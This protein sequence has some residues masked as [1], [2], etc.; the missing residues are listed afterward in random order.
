MERV[1]RIPTAYNL[2]IKKELAAVG[3]WGCELT[4]AATSSDG[5]LCLVDQR[6]GTEYYSQGSISNR[7]QA[8]RACCGD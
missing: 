1:P 7:E 5:N 8:V 6:S 4:G 2:F 3:L